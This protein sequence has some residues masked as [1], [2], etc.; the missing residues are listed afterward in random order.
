VLLYCER[1]VEYRCCKLAHVTF[2]RSPELAGEVC[3]TSL[4]ALVSAVLSMGQ[5]PRNSHRLL[6]TCPISIYLG[7]VSTQKP[8]ISLSNLESLYG[9]QP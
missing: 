1:A 2:T 8:F 9:V 4:A 3:H 7:I 6:A 5:K